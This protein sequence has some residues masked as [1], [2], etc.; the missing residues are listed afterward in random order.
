LSLGS[1]GSFNVYVLAKLVI[2][3]SIPN[4]ILYPL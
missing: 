1:L 3:W 4:I 2:A